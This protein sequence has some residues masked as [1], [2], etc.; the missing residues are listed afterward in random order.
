MRVSK[1]PKKTYFCP[2]NKKL[3]SSEI[4]I[5]E[6]SYYFY[7]KWC[8]AKFFD[9]KFCLLFNALKKTFNPSI[10]QRPFYQPH[11]FVPVYEFKQFRFSSLSSALGIWS[12]FIY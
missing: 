4:L 9:I 8:I 11:L 5:F 1:F 2:K 12:S 6:I 3:L 7:D 10:Y